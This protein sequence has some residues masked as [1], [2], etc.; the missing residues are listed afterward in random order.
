[1]TLIGQTLFEASLLFFDYHLRIGYE[2]NQVKFLHTFLPQARL[3][4]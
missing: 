3:D 2:R 4:C 1:M